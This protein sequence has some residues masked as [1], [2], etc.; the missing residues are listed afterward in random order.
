MGAAN[1]RLQDIANNSG[2][3]TLINSTEG[4]LAFKTKYL[5]D[6]GTSRKISISDGTS[7]NR[8]YITPYQGV[9]SRLRYIFTTG[10]VNQADLQITG[11]DLTSENIFAIVWSN[12]RF[13]FWSNG[14]KISEDTNGITPSQGTFNLLTLGSELNNNT[15]LYQGFLDFIA[16]FPILT[17]SEIHSL[18]TQ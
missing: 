17:D 9:P 13:E 7:S 8:L 10:G 4:V 1:T 14:V 12:N 15:E 18:T 16:V 2:N 3:S 11:L 6:D 5:V